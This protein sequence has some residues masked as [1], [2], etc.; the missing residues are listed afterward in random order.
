MNRI[1]LFGR[2]INDTIKRAVSVAS[3]DAPS[4]YID[5]RRCDF[6]FIRTELNFVNYVRDPELADVHVFVT[7]EQTGGGGREYQFSFIGRRRFEGTS[8]TLRHH[9]GQGCH[10][11]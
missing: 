11:C 3:I 4:F 2:K 5:C 7:D 6:D 8:Y 1:P 9:I 10:S